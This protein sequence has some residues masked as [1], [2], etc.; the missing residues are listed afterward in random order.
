MLTPG[1]MKRALS[2]P[3]WSLT[4]MAPRRPSA[5]RSRS[6]AG[7]MSMSDMGASCARA[8][9]RTDE[10]TKF[11][12]SSGWAHLLPI[13][14]AYIRTTR[15]D[16]V[17]PLLE[18]PPCNGRKNARLVLTLPQMADAL[19][20]AVRRFPR[21]ALP[22]PVVR[23]VPRRRVVPRFLDAPERRLVREVG[24]RRSVRPAHDLGVLRAQA[25]D[26][27]TAR[28]LGYFESTRLCSA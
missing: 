3:W 11:S 27:L 19:P 12:S 10:H 4:M 16:R 22:S 9:R 7:R 1:A 2:K 26:T 28:A 20:A 15:H 6:S 18:A 25:A 21:R 24:S 13:R 14:S 5:G 17:P 8:A 23:A